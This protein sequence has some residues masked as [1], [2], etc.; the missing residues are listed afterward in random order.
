MAVERSTRKSSNRFLFL[1]SLLIILLGTIWRFGNLGGDSFWHDE[2][3]TVRNAQ[4]GLQ[5]MYDPHHAPLLHIVTYSVI[6]TI[7]ETEFTVRLPAAIAGVLALVLM[8][9]FGRVIGRPRAGLWAALLLAVLPFHLRYS[10]EIRYYAPLMAFSLLT[11]IFLHQAL[12]EPKMKKWLAFALATVLNLYTHYGAFVVLGWQSIVIGVWLFSR[13]IK[14]Q[15]RVIFH[16]A[17]AALVVII[18]YAPWFQQL[19]LAI[20]INTGSNATGGT[21][22]FTPPLS[23]WVREAFKAFGFGHGLLPYLVAALCII[24]FAVWIW[25][26]DWITFSLVAVGLVAPLL[27]VTRFD[28]ARWAFPKY[29]IYMLPLYL[30]AAGVA[31]DFLFGQI[32]QRFETRQRLASVAMPLLAAVALIIVTAPLLREEHAYIEGDWKGITQQTEQTAQEGDVFVSMALDLPNGYNQGAFVW[33][34]Y[35]DKAFNNYTFVASNHLLPRDVQMLAN[36]NSD[37]WMVLLNRR[38]PIKFQEGT[39]QVTP[40]QNSLFLVHPTIQADSDL[41]KLIAMYEQMIPM[42]VAPSPQ[43]LLRH[44]LAAMYFVAQDYELAE[45]MS[46]EATTQCPEGRIYEPNRY[47]LL[48]EIYQALLEEYGRTGETEKIHQIEEKA[49]QVAAELLR[50]DIREPSAL[51]VLAVTDLLQMFEAGDAQVSENQVP[52][53]VE[54]RRFTMPQNGDWSDVLFMH[55]GASV[56]WQVALPEEP[57]ALSFRAAMDPNSWD[58]GGDGGTFVVQIETDTGSPQELYRRHVT[59]E[60]SDRRW[61]NELVSLA[62][63]AGQ[64]VTLTLLTEPGPRMDFTGDWAGWGQL[65]IVLEP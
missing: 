9:W 62:E 48:N 16:V 1:A 6:N 17:I 42:A 24:G 49:R 33:P 37:F 13:I 19:L 65:L 55:S 43:C 64:K 5:A 15:F 39:A 56:S 3:V 38:I 50:L 12:T 59:N 32:G 36:T 34:Y 51:P 58:W 47:L 28:V 45:Q 30:I 46:I 10:Q 40:F 35:L 31:L 60:D 21:T 57:T 4:A 61:R 22:E 2:M 54:V 25:R 29:I 63:Y 7:G 11:F 41:L 23:T 18:L 44:D 27:L 26:R 14:G 52:E 8:I 20:D 53:P